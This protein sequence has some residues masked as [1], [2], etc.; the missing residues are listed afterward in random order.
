M[1]STPSLPDLAW[2]EVVAL[3]A[4][5]EAWLRES[6]S[7]MDFSEVEAAIGRDFRL[8]SPDGKMEE[9]EAVLAWIRDAR[10]SRG[11]D[12][13]IVALDPRAI[14]TGDGAVLLEYSEQQYRDGQTTRRRSTALFLANPAAPRGMEWRHLQ[15]TWIEAGWTFRVPLGQGGI[16]DEQA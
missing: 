12:F 15:E 11:P 16:C 3:H 6:E 2:Q 4:F 7:V 8:I 1:N 9:R 10:G 13:K 5:F 14:W